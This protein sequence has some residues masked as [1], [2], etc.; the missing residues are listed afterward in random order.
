MNPEYDQQVAEGE[1]LS[2]DSSFE[3]GNLDRVVMVGSHEYDLFM[4]QDTNSR[5]HHQWFYFKVSYKK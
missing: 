4:R 2:F 5:R 1:V 3:S